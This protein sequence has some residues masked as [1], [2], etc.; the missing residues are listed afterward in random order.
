MI[1]RDSM[2]VHAF[3]LG[4]LLAALLGAVGAQS[5]PEASDV[6][7]TTMFGAIAFTAD[8]SYASVWKSLGE[9]ESEADVLKRYAGFGRG[10]CKVVSFDGRLCAALAS[11]KGRRGKGHWKLA[12][13]AGGTTASN[14]QA[15]AMERCNGD[16]RTGRR[17]QLRT[18]VCGDGR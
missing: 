5:S 2:Q 13:T 6:T 12:F 18:L 15:T 7:A 1:V 9:A 3:S 17:C 8:G 14:A 10:A 4:V 11:F 16:K